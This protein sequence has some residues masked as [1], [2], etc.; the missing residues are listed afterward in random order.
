MDRLSEQQ[1]QKFDVILMISARSFGLCPLLEVILY[2]L[3]SFG[4]ELAVR[5]PDVERCPLLGGS[6]C[7]IS[8]GKSN[9]GHGICPLYR[10][11]PPLG[12]SIIRGFTVHI[13]CMG[14][15]HVS[16]SLS[17]SLSHLQERELAEAKRRKL[18]PPPAPS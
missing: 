5:C 7:T 17:L 9:R 13:I 4:G 11:C 15:C 14:T 1:C 10:G 6:E 3:L 2:R 18:D 12:E 16:L 8:M